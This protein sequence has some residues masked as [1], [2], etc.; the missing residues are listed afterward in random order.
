MHHE[1]TEMIHTK[2]LVLRPFSLDDAEQAYANWLSDPVV[3]HMAGWAPHKDMDSARAFIADV[4]AAY[5]SPTVLRW[6]ITLDG[7]VIGDISVTKW[8]ERHESCELG[9]ALSQKWWGRGLMPEALCAVTRYLFDTVG[10]HRIALRRHADNV[11]SGRVMAKTGYLLEGCQKDARK[12]ADGT[13]TDLLLYAAINGEWQD[14]QK[15]AIN[16]NKTEL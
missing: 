16:Q 4:T 3:A 1:G 10:F 8:N 11:R 9:Y 6:G 5:Q 7:N 14:T 2:R 15:K 13:F 12:N